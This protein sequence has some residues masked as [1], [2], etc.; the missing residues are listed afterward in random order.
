MEV[1]PVLGE[2]VR[3]QEQCAAVG[4]RRGQDVQGLEDHP[5]ELGGALGRRDAGGCV[6]HHGARLPDRH[7]HRELAVEAGEPEPQVRG[8][9]LEHGGEV[10]EPLRQV[11]LTGGPAGVDQQEDGG[12]RSG[13]RVGL[14]GGGGEGDASGAHLDAPDVCR[15]RQT[16]VAT[17]GGGFHGQATRAQGPVA[18]EERGRRLGARRRDERNAERERA[19]EEPQRMEEA[20]HGGGPFR[21]SRGREGDAERERAPQEPQR[22][23]RGHHVP[24]EGPSPCTWGRSSSAAAAPRRETPGPTS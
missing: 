16:E 18:G 22:L 2:A 15:V 12:E 5:E 14:P 17:Q 21:P 11:Q 24:S 20:H 19:P 7:G 3:E 9:G 6:A 8:G 10:L 1:G 23:E 13:A 4:R